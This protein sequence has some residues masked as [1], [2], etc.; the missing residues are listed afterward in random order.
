MA[1]AMACYQQACLTNQV[2][3][4]QQ[5][6]VSTKVASYANNTP[7]ISCI[8]KNKPSNHVVCAVWM[9]RQPPGQAATHVPC[10]SAIPAAATIT[11]KK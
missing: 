2:A 1:P 3:L 9:H 11:V 10:S 7:G 5:G 8:P 6:R 4:S